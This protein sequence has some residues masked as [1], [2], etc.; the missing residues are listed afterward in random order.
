[1]ADILIVDVTGKT[2]QVDQ[3]HSPTGIGTIIKERPVPEELDA[4]FAASLTYPG[5]IITT[6]HGVFIAG[7]HVVSVLTR[8]TH[9]D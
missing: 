3:L 4:D 6:N 2:H 9:D 7:A 8:V 1:M 5:A